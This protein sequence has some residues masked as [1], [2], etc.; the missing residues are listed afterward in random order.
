MRVDILVFMFILKYYSGKD[1]LWRK[2]LKGLFN[3]DDVAV[4][5]VMYVFPDEYGICRMLLILN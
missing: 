1:S 3:D 2:Q 4:S 5:L